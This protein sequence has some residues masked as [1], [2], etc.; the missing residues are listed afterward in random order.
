M[1]WRKRIAQEIAPFLDD[2]LQLLGPAVMA[3]ALLMCA[4]RLGLKRANARLITSAVLGSFK[5]S[6]TTRNELLGHIERDPGGFWDLAIDRDAGRRQGILAVP[7]GG[8][9]T[10]TA[11]EGTAPIPARQFGQPAPRDTNDRRL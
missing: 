5:Q 1:I 10:G 3:Q 11:I 8:S 2:L 9:P 7:K 4:A 6:L